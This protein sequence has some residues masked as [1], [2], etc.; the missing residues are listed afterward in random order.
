MRLL[1]T[2]ENSDWNEK[3]NAEICMFVHG[4]GIGQK[5][6]L[7]ASTWRASLMQQDFNAGMS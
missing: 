3:L 2:L 7:S 1:A 5:D 4:G 6:D